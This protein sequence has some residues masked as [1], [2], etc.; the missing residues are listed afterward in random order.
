METS[1]GS[2]LPNRFESSPNEIFPV[3]YVFEFLAGAKSVLALSAAPN[4]LAILGLGGERGARRYLLTNL[5]V[6]S[7]RVRC[8]F[9]GPSFTV[10]F[11]DDVNVARLRRGLQSEGQVHQVAD[12]SSEIDFPG[13]SIAFITPDLE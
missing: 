8:R 11:L 13:M 4:G 3:Y 6:A 7:K 2:P 12:G 1:Q 5:E 10:R 9:A